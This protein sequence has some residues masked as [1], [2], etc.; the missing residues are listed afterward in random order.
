MS[1]AN[2]FETVDIPADVPVARLPPEI[3]AAI[4]SMLSL[5]PILPPKGY[6]LG[7]NGALWARIGWL[8][9]THVCRRW[10]Y[11]ALQHPALWANI[12]IPHPLGDHWA[13]AS[14]S[15]AQDAPLTI[16]QPDDS[17]PFALRASDH[18]FIRAN[19]ARTRVLRLN[20]CTDPILDILCTPAPVLHALDLTFSNDPEQALP[21]S[22]LSGAPLRHLRLHVA[23]QLPWTSPLLSNLVSLELE[24]KIIAHVRRAALADV[25]GA[26]GRMRTL[27]RLAV[28]L[29]LDAAD[30]HAAGTVALPQL[31]HLH[32]RADIASAH[33][34][35]A[36]LVLPASANMHFSV[37]CEASAHPATDNAALFSAMIAS[38]D[39]RPPLSHIRITRSAA[40]AGG[41]VAAWRAGEAR[42][43]PALAVTL[44]DSGSVASAA[45]SALASE[46]LEELDVY[47]ADAGE[48]WLTALRNAPRLR[49]AAVDGPAVRAFCGA[50][51]DASFL[52]ALSALVIA[53]PSSV[54]GAGALTDVHEACARRLQEAAPGMD[55]KWRWVWR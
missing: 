20:S 7:W 9:V 27:E 22:F 48:A 46:H 24:T 51:E 41:H 15:R 6:R 45:L 23:G 47:S 19:L 10:R 8:N 3:L 12:T 11:V 40:A 2:S 38:F 42:R 32:L 55:V 5:S 49:H 50:L 31:R 37:R 29:A 14:F 28:G 34:L 17:G 52:P 26:L 30:A 33:R 54:V 44:S 16:L 43:G 35:L 53:G 13:D 4:F 18:A 39:G 25:L 1:D 36:H 21:D